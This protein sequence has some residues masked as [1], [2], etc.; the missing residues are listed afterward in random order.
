MYLGQC[1]QMQSNIQ[2]GAKVG[3]AAFL[4]LD[5]LLIQS[6]DCACALPP[7]QAHRASL[8]EFLPLIQSNVPGSP[9]SKGNHGGHC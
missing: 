9:S 4:T 7:M 8:L 6:I 5:L 2:D 3:N 1:L